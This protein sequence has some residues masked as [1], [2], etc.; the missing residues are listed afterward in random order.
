[1]PRRRPSAV[2][3]R[4]VAFEDLGLLAPILHDA[5]IYFVGSRKQTRVDNRATTACQ[6][7]HG[8]SQVE[9]A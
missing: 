2:V 8:P 4:H 6:S 1:M 9:S 7:H 3:L 5:C